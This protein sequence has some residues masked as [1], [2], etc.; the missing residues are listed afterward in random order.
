MS[1]SLTEFSAPSV[2]H[3]LSLAIFGVK[4]LS[5]ADKQDM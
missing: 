5:S 3:V 1:D 2:V 4:D